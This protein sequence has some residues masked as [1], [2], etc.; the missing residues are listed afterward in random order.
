LVN[1]WHS[2][3]GNF[4]KHVQ[5]GISR[6]EN[7]TWYGEV[8]QTIFGDKQTIRGENPTSFL[9]CPQS[10]LI[11]E[12]PHTDAY[13]ALLDYEI[14]LAV[15]PMPLMGSTAP[16]SMIS[17]LVLANCEVLAMLC[18]LQAA[19][20]GTPFIY[21]P[22]LAMINPRSA[23]L[24]AGTVE[25]ALMGAAAVEMARY[26]GLPVIA[27]GGGSDHHV[28]SI[29]VGYEGAIGALPTLLTWPDILIGP[30]LLSGSMILSFEQLIIDVEIYRMGRRIYEGID[31]A[32][33]RWLDDVIDRVGPGGDFIAELSTVE[34][35]RGGEWHLSDFGWHDTFEAW[36]TAG[37]P[38]LLD[39]AREM[40]DYL[41]ETHAPS[42]LGEDVEREL[43]NIARRAEQVID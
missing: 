14:P 27:S 35:I 25:S 32:E 29:Q 23:K 41:L 9:V 7:A 13:L 43:K 17:T 5:N 34:G 3:F 37:R 24:G 8:L 39:E 22:A 12:G 40:V 19:A 2:L 4:S 28:P 33:N 36:E 18:L 21:A 11:I 15:M 31:S 38:Q 6:Q 16:G 42:P 10:P 26:Y 20:P 1:Y 30:G